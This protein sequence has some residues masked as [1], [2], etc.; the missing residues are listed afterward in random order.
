M[1]SKP[2]LIL[3]SGHVTKRTTC[4]VG[5]MYV[6]NKR[7]ATP[8]T[9]GVEQSGHATAVGDLLLAVL[10]TGG[11]GCDLETQANVFFSS[12]Y[13]SRQVNFM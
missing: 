10:C 4:L 1:G 6:G 8:F 13:S 7:E 9:W 11:D 12:S 2:W 3:N 5:V